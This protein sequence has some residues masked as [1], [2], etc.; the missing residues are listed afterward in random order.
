MSLRLY[1]RYHLAVLTLLITC[2]AAA[3]S[4]G[5][6]D[7]DNTADQSDRQRPLI[8]PR[9][10]LHVDWAVDRDHEVACEGDAIAG[11]STS[12]GAVFSS[13]GRSHIT[14]SGAWDVGHPIS[15]PQFQPIGPAGGPVAPVLGPGEYPYAFHFD[16]RIPDCAA[17]LVATGEVVITAANGDEV[18]GSVQ[19]GEAHR[20][21]FQQPGDGVET[22]VIVEIAGG[23]GRFQNATGSFTMHTIIRFDPGLGRFVLDFAEVMPGG[24]IGF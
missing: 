2:L 24:T 16:P 17:G 5:R 9:S 21:D 15:N 19:G 18:H 10:D 13:L 1:G 7:H 3:T 22:F 20:L 14:A 23:T 11:G 6:T 12:G 4:H 8:M